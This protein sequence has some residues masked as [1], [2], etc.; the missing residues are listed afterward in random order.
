MEK[1]ICQF[2]NVVVSFEWERKFV[3]ELGG[4][5]QIV[6]KNLKKGSCSHFNQD[7]LQYNC[8]LDPNSDIGA[9]YPFEN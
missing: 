1:K 2:K 4:H 8:L 5:G 6:Q 3:R 7:C 9:E